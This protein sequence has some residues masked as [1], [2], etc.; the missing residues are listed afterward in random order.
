MY[1]QVSQ[2]RSSGV[3]PQGILDRVKEEGDEIRSLLGK[4]EQ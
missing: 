4:G 1:Q 2:S 3:V